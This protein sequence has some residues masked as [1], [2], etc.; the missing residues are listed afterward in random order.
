MYNI[1]LRI[2]CKFMDVV[3]NESMINES[4]FFSECLVYSISINPQYSEK[5]P[6]NKGHLF[7]W[8]CPILVHYE[9][10]KY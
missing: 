3:K 1:L 4:I 5:D 8:F 2:I 9:T 7:D 10:S 6:L